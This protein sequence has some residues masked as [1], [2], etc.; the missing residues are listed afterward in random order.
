MKTLGV[1]LTLLALGI[2]GSLVF[3]TPTQ[4][5][6]RNPVV[7]IG[8]IPLPVTGTISVGNLGS[9]TLPVSVTNLP[10]T[11]QVS[12]T[13]DI[14]TSDADKYTHVGQKP[15]QLVD[16]RLGNF[17]SLRINPS[18]GDAEGFSIPAGF[19]LVLTDIE[20]S[21]QCTTAGESLTFILGAGNRDRTEIHLVCPGSGWASFDRNYSTG[22]VFNA[23]ALGGGG[24]GAIRA[25]HWERRW[26]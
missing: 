9:T 15:S 26:H 4:A 24:V 13:V 21:I 10:T 20:G 22:W 14:G 25:G 17:S 5:A 3:E 18:S 1:V 16:L 23:D 11:Q 7:T 19:V 8:N 12:G 6:S 2:V